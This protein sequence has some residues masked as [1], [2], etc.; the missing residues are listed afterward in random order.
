LVPTIQGWKPF[1]CFIG[2]PVYT[3]GCPLFWSGGGYAIFGGGG[4]TEPL[5]GGSTEPLGGGYWL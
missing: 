1:Q 2:V 5:G 3:G 4:Y